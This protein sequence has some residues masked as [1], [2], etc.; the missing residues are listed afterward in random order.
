MAAQVVQNPTPVSGPNPNGVV[1]PNKS[2]NPNGNG[3][4]NGGN[5]GAAFVTTSLYVGDHDFIVTD[6]Y[7]LFNQIGQVVS[8]R[9]S[10]FNLLTQVFA[11]MQNLDKAIDHKS[12]HD[13]FSSF[14]NILSCKIATDSNG[15]SKGFGF[16]QFD[17]EEATQKAIEKLNGMLIN[18]KQE[19][20]TNTCRTKF[21][22]VFVRNLSESITDEDLKK[23]FGE[24]GPITSAV[25]MRDADG[26]SRCFGLVNFDN[27]DDAANVVEALNGKKFDDKEW[28]VG[29]ALKKSEREQELKRKFEQSMKEATDKYQGANL[30]VKNLDDTVDDEK[31]KDL[32]AEYGKITSCKVMHDP[33]G[34]SKGSGFV[35]FSSPDEASRAQ[36]LV[37]FPCTEERR[38]KSTFAGETPDAH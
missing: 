10:V 27:A 35:A 24:F 30:Y 26:K 38:K 9:L 2:P 15:Q 36:A 17:T 1:S 4:T 14:G 12:L 21:N 16:V 25:V 5:S 20:D 34:I 3:G 23:V 11:F 22:N 29:K 18:D 6:F 19:R 8:V 28:Y 13:T 32:F 33:S 37:C 31:P 7:D